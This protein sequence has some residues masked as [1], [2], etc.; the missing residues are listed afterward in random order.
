[1]NFILM[2]QI[3]ELRKQLEAVCDYLGIRIERIE[4]KEN[5]KVVKLK[6]KKREEENK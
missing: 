6:N 4:Q 1:M 5:V 3:Q 2:N